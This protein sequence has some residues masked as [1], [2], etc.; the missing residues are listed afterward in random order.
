MLCAA[1]AAER[2]GN[3]EEEWWELGRMSQDQAGQ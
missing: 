3:L 2:M 1:A